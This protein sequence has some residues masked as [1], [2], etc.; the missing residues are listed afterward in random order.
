MAIT[1]CVEAAVF[2]LDSGAVGPL[3]D[4]S[5]LD[6]GEEV[7]IVGPL[8]CD[9]PRENQSRR[10]VPHQHLAPIALAAVDVAL[11]PAAPGSRPS[12]TASSSSSAADVELAWPPAVVP[13]GEGRERLL[14]RCLD[15]D[16]VANGGALCGGSSGL[17]LFVIVF[18]AWAAV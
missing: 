18:G 7:S 17:L 2:E 8:T 16:R 11:V 14:L 6:L 12:I 5:H 10:R 15:D 1:V 3:R 4:E 9:L 13:A